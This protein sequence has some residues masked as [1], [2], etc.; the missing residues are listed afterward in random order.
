[1]ASHFSI[2]ASRIPGFS[3][4]PRVARPSRPGPPGAGLFERRWRDGPGRRIAPPD[5]VRARGGLGAATDRTAPP[6]HYSGSAEPF[7]GRHRTHAATAVPPLSPRRFLPCAP[8]FL[9]QSRDRGIR[10]AAARLSHCLPES[11]DAAPA[12]IG[13][14][15]GLPDYAAVAKIPA[16]HDI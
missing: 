14:S 15:Q 7:R 13:D 3:T 1:S 4:L 5:A 11:P 9:A 16:G 8:G 2:R 6:R 10:P 12:W